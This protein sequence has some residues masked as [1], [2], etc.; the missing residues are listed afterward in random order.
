MTERRIHAEPEKKKFMQTSELKKHSCT[1]KF[2]PPP[3]PPSVI[4][5]GPPLDK[6]FFEKDK[7]KLKYN[8]T[9]NKNACGSPASWIPVWCFAQAV[10]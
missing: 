9:D 3:L 5:N 4:S 8:D 7:L 1:E 10:K 2:S 6:T